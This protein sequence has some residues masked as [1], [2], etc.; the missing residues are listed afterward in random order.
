[1]AYGFNLHITYNNNKTEY[2]TYIVRPRVL[3]INTWMYVRLFVCP[4]VQISVAIRNLFFF[5]SFFRFQSKWLEYWL[6]QTIS[7][8]VVEWLL[9]YCFFFF[10]L[11]TVLSLALFFSFRNEFIPVL[12]NHTYTLFV[13]QY[14]GIRF[15]CPV[16]MN[17][18]FQRKSNVIMFV[19]MG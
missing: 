9:P 17:K 11:S 8:Y 14:R 5:A 2:T 10:L 4:P 15:A 3:S 7:I 18:R 19:W 16:K 13:H 12:S 1:M 6:L